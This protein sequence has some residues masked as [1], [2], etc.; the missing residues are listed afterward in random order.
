MTSLESKEMKVN[1]YTIGGK[2]KVQ[3]V[4]SSFI[5]N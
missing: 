1:F 2:Y 3:Y 4:F 5:G